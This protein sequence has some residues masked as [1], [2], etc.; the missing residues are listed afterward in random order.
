MPLPVYREQHSVALPKTNEKRMYMAAP[1][2]EAV[3]GQTAVIVV[4][5]ME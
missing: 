5:A 4:Q 3:N 2:T 1:Y